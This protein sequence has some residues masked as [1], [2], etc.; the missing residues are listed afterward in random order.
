VIRNLISGVGGLIIALGIAV[1][2]LITKG[3]TGQNSQA[4]NIVV[5]VLAG[6]LFVVGLG[7]LAFG[8][9]QLFTQKDDAEDED[10]PRRRKRRP[11]DDDEEEEEEERPRKRR[12]RAEEEVEVEEEE[13]EPPRRPRPP[14]PE[15]KKL[16]PRKPRPPV[17]DDDD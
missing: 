15:A 1:T 4:M 16:P 11:R 13:P 9:F 8:I 3:F 14:P 17:E 6:L 7:Y 12:P 2:M 10:R 5:Y